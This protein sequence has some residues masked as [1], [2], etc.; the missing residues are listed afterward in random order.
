MLSWVTFTKIHSIRISL[1]VIHRVLSTSITCIT[2][3][4]VSEKINTSDISV[5]I[6]WVTVVVS[7]SVSPCV[8]VTVSLSVC[9]WVSVFT[10]WSTGDC[11]VIYMGNTVDLV[12]MV[13]F[14]IFNFREFPNFQVFTKF[15]IREFSFF[16]S[17]G[18]II[19]IYARFLNSRI[20]R[21]KLKPRD[22]QI[23]SIYESL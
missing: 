23:Y 2:D 10:F 5:Y 3:L 15:R 4:T 22:Y 14:A 9:H 11:I 18:I 7:L 20:Y 13:I 6:Y 1:T 12:I 19:I 21:K 17:S 8:T 16:F